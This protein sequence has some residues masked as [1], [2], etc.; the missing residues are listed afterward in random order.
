MV[1]VT[2]FL[3][4]SLNLTRSSLLH[5]S[6]YFFSGEAVIDADRINPWF[7]DIQ[8]HEDITVPAKHY[9]FKQ[10]TLLFEVESLLR[11]ELL[12][13]IYLAQELWP[14]KEAR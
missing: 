2:S 1:A 14:T 6:F 9:I 8:G 7:Y 3:K 12:L 11:K 13:L 10:H 4:Q 5:L